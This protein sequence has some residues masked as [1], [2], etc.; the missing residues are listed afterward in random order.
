MSHACSRPLLLLPGGRLP[1]AW[2]GGSATTQG[3][4]VL[5]VGGAC[6]GIHAPGAPC[7]T[8]LSR[9]QDTGSTRWAEARQLHKPAGAQDRPLTRGAEYKSTRLALSL[10][11]GSRWISPREC[12]TSH[13]RGTQPEHGE[14]HYH[15]CVLLT[16][17]RCTCCTQY[18][19]SCYCVL[20][21]CAL[22]DRAAPI[23]PVSAGVMKRA[24]SVWCA[25]NL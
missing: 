25:A 3:G 21:F 9:R 6:H 4:S 23:Q 10:V 18:G 24:A 12:G 7:S 11:C 20:L 1:V 16:T 22:H 8:A 19:T 15:W 5:L 14:W 13:E 17:A 2:T